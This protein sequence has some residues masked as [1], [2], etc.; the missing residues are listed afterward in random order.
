[1][2]GK[3]KALNEFCKFIDIC[4][5]VVYTCVCKIIQKD[6]MISNFMNVFNINSGYYNT[7]YDYDLVMY[8][9]CLL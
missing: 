6:V 4:P 2:D 8:D 1:M 9:Y 7:K 3:P 5:F